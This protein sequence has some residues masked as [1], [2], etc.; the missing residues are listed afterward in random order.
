MDLS[1][2]LAP[3]E[4]DVF[5]DHDMT[6]ASMSSSPRSSNG[7]D[8]PRASSTPHLR[9]GKWFPEEEQYALV[10]IECFILGAFADLATGTSLRSFLAEKLQCP[11]M[12]ISKKF[13]GEGHHLNFA[14]VSIPKKLG[15]KRYLRQNVDALAAAKL[16]SLGDLKASFLRAVAEEKQLDLAVKD[17]LPKRAMRSERGGLS[18]AANNRVGYWSR[19]E[20]TYASKLIEAFMKG[21]LQLRKGTSL[22]SF[23]AHR[24]G[25][26]PMRVS[27]KLATC[28]IA[29]MEIPRR[30]GTATY[31]PK[32]Y[33][34][35][36]MAEILQTE[37]E[38]QS[39]RALCFGESIDLLSSFSML[40]AAA[41][42]TT[43]GH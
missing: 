14:G 32:M 15:Q 28:A 42:T 23:L 33:Q 16:A 41:Q 7:G 1:R 37:R 21:Q 2:I 30:I 12:R 27:K 25:C 8:S 35:A 10:L 22:R 5:D 18:F 3:M 9:M 11:P 29:G 19:E 36:S 43:V 24:L 31:Q 26:N 20:Q 39:L 34:D 13:S 6:D 38:L 40:C 4:L 17:K